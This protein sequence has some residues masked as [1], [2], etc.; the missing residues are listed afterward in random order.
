MADPLTL[1]DLEDLRNR[2]CI[3]VIRQEL[4][5][6]SEIFERNLL[7]RGL[8][9]SGALYTPE[10]EQLSQQQFRARLY[11]RRTP[12]QVTLPEE[13]EEMI[14]FPIEDLGEQRYVIALAPV[15]EVAV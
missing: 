9:I 6:T 5:Q 15:Q 13:D 3:L 2:G 12:S 7:L 4:A 1:E 11:N 8:A 10:S 14:L